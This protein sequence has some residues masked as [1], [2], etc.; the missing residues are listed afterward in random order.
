MLKTLIVLPDGTEVFSG[1][2]NNS[3]ESATIKQK[4]NNAKILTLGSTCSAMLDVKLKTRDG[5]LSLSEGD[6][7][8]AYKVAGDGTRHLMGLFTLQKPT[9]TSANTMRITAY[10]RIT[11]LDKDLTDWFA[12]LDGWPYSLLTLAQMVC[13][14]C[15]LELTN[16]SIPNGDYQ[17][18]PFTARGIT[19]RKLMQ[20]AGEIAGRFCRA[21]L[22]GQIEFAWYEP[23]GV[24]ITPDGERFYCQNGL[25]YEDYSVALIE[26]VQIKQ[27]ADDVGTVWPDETG[28]KNTYIISGNYLLTATATEALLPVAQT[29]YEQLK[30]V[31]YT[32]CKVQLPA[33]LDIHAGHTVKITDRNGKSFTTFVMTKTQTGQRDT[34]ECTGSQRRDSTT[35]VN[36]EKYQ[37]LSRQM[38]EVR[39]EVEG[40]T[41]TASKLDTDLRGVG[42]SV[43]NAQESIQSV[44]TSIGQLYADADSIR[45]SVSDVEKTVDSV[46]G[47]LQATRS[48]M[49]SMK[50]TSEELRVEIQKINDDG[51]KKVTTTTGIFDEAGLTVDKTDSPTKT[52]ITPD[53]MVVYKKTYGSGGSEVLSA[54]S[55]GVDATNLHAKTY[56]IIGGRSRFENYGDDRTGCFWI[57]G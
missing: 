30:A 50:L 41:V 42:D 55:D 14:A 54:T 15:G 17:V 26:K 2:G 33:G 56:L 23:S 53:G 36:N 7:V 1:G 29:L 9:R 13:E 40:L 48:E 51:V 8:T 4:V 52:Q 44:Q 28:E 37:A 22:E 20:W 16:D 39:K 5:G 21:T 19:G 24:E 25:S 46:S 47:D 18:Q 11:W 32:P 34:L 35:V 10:D 3:V 57:G 12:S 45:A 31:T 38:L 6:E 49:A 43:A 27:S